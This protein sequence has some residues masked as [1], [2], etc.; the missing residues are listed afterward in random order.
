MHLS[1]SGGFTIPENKNPAVLRAVNEAFGAPAIDNTQQ[2][3][4]GLS[5]DL[6]FRIVVKGS[7]YLLRVMTQINERNDPARLFGA[8]RAAAEAA[9]APRVW[10]ANTEDG[11]S[12]TDFV[13]AVPLST[14]EAL[15]RIPKTLRNIHALPPF[16]TALNFVTVHNLFIW[17]F[18]TANLLPQN[19]IEEVFT[20]YAQLSAVYPRLDADM[21]SCHNNLK[22]E[23]ILFDGARVWLVDWQ[24][25]FRNDRYFDLAIVANFLVHNDSDETTYLSVYFGQPPDEYQRARF[26]LMRQAMHLFY[27]AVFLLLGSPAKPD[28]Q[29]ENSPDFQS[30]HQRIWAGEISLADNNAKTVYGMVHWRRLLYN[31][32]QSSFQDAL[33]AVID[34]HAS[35]P[36]TPL[37][38]PQ[39][40]PERPDL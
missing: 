32:R 40:P 11:I 36:G 9:Q 21:V 2:L 30:F 37:L 16:P 10:Y 14:A 25:A 17:R 22:P 38:F 39:Y 6:I 8:M 18:R 24:A 19:E 13:D 27:A 20:R 7:P 3:T 5:S 34:R 33:A 4:K 31:V 1:N 15:V 35:S 12:I 28:D 29:T 23:N 26:F